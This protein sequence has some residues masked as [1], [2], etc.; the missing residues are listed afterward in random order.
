MQAVLEKDFPRIEANIKLSRPAQQIYL[1]KTLKP[2]QAR[3][4]IL[5]DPMQEIWLGES[6]YLWNYLVRSSSAGF[7]IALSVSI[8]YDVPVS[9]C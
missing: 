2:S 5:L 7:F 3:D 4:A 9:K 6:L 8:Q 1:S